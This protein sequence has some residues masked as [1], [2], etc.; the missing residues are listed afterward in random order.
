MITK[1]KKYK[2][3]LHCHT[4]PCSACSSMT[5]SELID[6]LVAG[7]YSGCVITNHF[8]KGNTGINRDLTWNEFVY[9]YEKDY[10]ECK[11][12]AQD[13][14]LDIIFGIEE[15]VGD[16]LEILCYG[17]TP[18]FLYD[19]PE[20]QSDRSVKAWHNALNKFD[21]LCI[22]AHPYRDRPYIINPRPLPFDFIDG[23]EVY[24]YCNKS[25]END[26]AAELAE[27]HTDFIL[28]SGADAHSGDLMCM[29][30]I[31]TSVRITDEKQLVNVLKTGNYTL[32]K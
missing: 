18:Q 28:T 6:G 13:R 21:A 24:N 30:G 20:L 22:Q 14:D 31:E 7:G 4:K 29:A 9:Q 17:I 11:N 15:G 27:R 3:Q 5:P 8:Y 25:I 26:L 32:I 16:G 23:I 12:L 1:M 10:I 19:N 2:Y